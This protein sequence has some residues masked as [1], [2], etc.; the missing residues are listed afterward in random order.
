MS[1]NNF[2][3]PQMRRPKNGMPPKKSP[4]QPNNNWVFWIILGFIFLILMSQNNSMAPMGKYQELSYNAFYKI[5]EGENT[6]QRIKQIKLVESTENTL[7]GT[8]DD[9][10]Q[11]KVVIPQNYDDSLIQL[12]RA[13]VDDFSI[14]PPD[15]L[16]SQIFFSF[17]P[18]IFI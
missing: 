5:L 18:I 2:N 17:G 4:Q 9:G 8:F 14:N 10:T 15:L 6:S 1:K 3:R 16:W 12:I 13:N 11:F 7:E